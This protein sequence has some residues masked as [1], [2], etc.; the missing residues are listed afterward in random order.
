MPEL[1]KDTNKSQGNEK[2]FY[3]GTEEYSAPYSE[4]VFDPDLRLTRERKVPFYIELL[5]ANSQSAFKS[6][7]GVIPPQ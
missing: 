7:M 1:I 5:S 6:D 4:F 3:A 2:E